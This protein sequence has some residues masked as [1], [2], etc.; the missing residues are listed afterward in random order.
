MA[1][2]LLLYLITAGLTI[3]KAWVHQSPQRNHLPSARFLYRGDHLDDENLKK[4]EKMFYMKNRRYSP[5]NKQAYLKRVHG[6]NSS[7]VLS[8]RTIDDLAQEF[9]DAYEQSVKDDL[10]DELDK[11]FARMID[12][13][14]D[15]DDFPSELSSEYDGRQEDGNN[16]GYLAPDGVFRYKDPAIFFIPKTKQSS[17]SNSGDDTDTGSQFQI[18]KNSPYSFKDIGGYENVKEELLQTS[19]ILINYEKYKKFN[20]RTP[21]GMIFEGPPGNGKTLMA[22]GFSGE[23]NV[24]FI[25]VSGSEFSEKYVGVGA[26]RIRELFKLA[27]DNKPCIIFIDEIDALA[28]KRGNDLVTSNSEK[29]QTLNQLLINLDGFKDSH[30]VFVIGATNRLDLLDPALVRAGRMDKNIYIGNPDRKTRGEIIK[31]HKVGKP[32]DDEITMDYM[33]EMTGGFSAAQIENLLNESMLRALRMNREIIKIEDLE[34]I[35]NRIL[36]GWQ[37]KESQFSDDMIERIIIHE[38]GHAIVGVFC[39]EHPSLVKVCLNL[40]SPKTPGYTIFDSN[41][42]NSNIYTKTG[43]FSHLMVLLS[44][45][46]AE[47]VFFGYSVTTGAK[48][49]FEE[50]YKLAQ[51]MILQ[52]G[53]GKKTI[54]PDSSDYSKY[55]I[56][57]EVNELILSA[58]EE[59]LEIISQ[60]KD[61]ICDCKDILKETSILKPEQI[62]DII[63]ERHRLLLNTYPHVLEKITS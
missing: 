18:I 46:I 36:A 29:D 27:N 7:L 30:G 3:T 35:A 43:L 28:R 6:N 44:G 11:T 39:K 32:M 14:A 4:L 24:S 37:A 2:M 12:E 20:V 13:A 55:V 1:I 51:S 45:R 33:V 38:M 56:D 25:P 15:M 8:K 58:Q 61:L 23:I 41:D 9:Q 17:S 42:E 53:M 48:K 16:N 34:Y 31:I 10:D 5:Y 21:K 26:S 59:A 47:D 62:M 54:Y 40:W 49:D 52:Y 50:A 63:Q 57:Q 60:C 19:D 22:K